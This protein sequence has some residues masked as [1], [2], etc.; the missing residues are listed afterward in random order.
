MVLDCI[1]DEEKAKEAV[2]AKKAG[3][4]KHMLNL[5]SSMELLNTNK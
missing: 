3:S 2:E 5:Q 1:G 4:K